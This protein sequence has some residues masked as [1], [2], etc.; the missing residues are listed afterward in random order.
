MQDK[1]RIKESTQ[2]QSSANIL[3]SQLP[4]RVIWQMNVPSEAQLLGITTNAE[5]VLDEKFTSCTNLPELLSSSTPW[6]CITQCLLKDPSVLEIIRQNSDA[7]AA[8]LITA[9][10]SYRDLLNRSK[11]RIQC[12]LAEADEVELRQVLSLLS[13]CPFTESKANRPEVE[14]PDGDS[15]QLNTDAKIGKD[16]R[17]VVS[18]SNRSSESSCSAASSETIRANYTTLECD[19][20]PNDAKRAIHRAHSRTASVKHVN[21]LKDEHADPSEGPSRGSGSHAL[22]QSFSDV[23]SLSSCAQRSGFAILNQ[24]QLSS[25]ASAMDARYSTLASRQQALR[26]LVHLPIIDVQAC[27]A[28]K[29]AAQTEPRE[30]IQETDEDEANMEATNNADHASQNE[31]V[32]YGGLKNRLAEALDDEDETLWSLALRYV[33]KGLSTTPQNIRESFV[34]L[35]VHIRNLFNKNIRNIPCVSDGINLATNPVNRMTRACHLMNQFH[36]DIPHYWVRYSEQFLNEILTRSL[37]VL[38]IGCSMGSQLDYVLQPVN[39]LCLL[40]LIDYKAEWFGIWMHSAYSRDPIINHLQKDPSLLLFCLQVLFNFTNEKNQDGSLAAVESKASSSSSNGKE[41]YSAAE[42]N[43]A[44]F[45]HSVSIICFILSHS[46]GRSLLNHIELA[47]IRPGHPCIMNGSVKQLVHAMLQYLLQEKIHIQPTCYGRNALSSLVKGLMDLACQ[48]G[49]CIACF[50]SDSEI[51]SND[52]P[53]HLLLT[54]LRCFYEKTSSTDAQYHFTQTKKSVLEMQIQLM[55]CLASHR[56][57]L[58]LLRGLQTKI[59]EWSISTVELFHE[60]INRS[61]AKYE[62]PEAGNSFLNDRISVDQ[63]IA[64]MQISM[65][66]H[67]LSITPEL[68]HL[69]KLCTQVLRLWKTMMPKSRD[70]KRGASAMELTHI[71]ERAIRT[72]GLQLAETCR[73]VAYLSCAGLLHECAQ[74]LADHLSNHSLSLDPRSAGIIFTQLCSTQDGIEALLSAGLVDKQFVEVW[75]RLSINGH[76]DCDSASNVSTSSMKWSVDPIDRTLFKPFIALV[77]LTSS[78]CAFGQ[79]FVT[80]DSRKA[81]D[82][83]KTKTSTPTSSIVEFLRALV[84]PTSTQVFLDGDQAQIFGMR[85]LSCMMADLDCMLFIEKQLNLLDGLLH[86]QNEN[87]SGTG[88]VI[89]DALSVERNYLLVKCIVTGG[90]NERILPHRLICEHTLDPYPYPMLTS[91]WSPE[92]LTAFDTLDDRNSLRKACAVHPCTSWY[93]QMFQED[94]RSFAS[95]CWSPLCMSVCQTS[96]SFMEAPNS[97]QTINRWQQICRDALFRSTF[98]AYSDFDD[99]HVITFMLRAVQCGKWLYETENPCLKELT[100][101][102]DQRAMETLLLA[103]EEVLGAQF[104]VRYGQRIGLLEHVGHWSEL[105]NTH[106]HSLCLLLKRCRWSLEN[107]TTS[108]QDTVVNS[109]AS[110]LESCFSHGFDWFAATVFLIS[111]GNLDSTWQFLSRFAR[112]IR[113]VYLWPIRGRLLFGKRSANSSL[114]PFIT[115]SCHFL[116]HIVALECPT[117]YNTFQ[118]VQLCPSQIFM[119]WVNQCFWN[120]LNWCDIVDY[121][122]T[123]LLHPAGYQIYFTVSIL[124]HLH[125][126]IAKCKLERPT[127][128][129][130]QPEQLIVFLQEEPIRGFHLKDHISYIN[131]LHDKYG[132]GLEPLLANLNPFGL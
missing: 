83:S 121:I 73:G 19:I 52:S 64:L 55:Q 117:L 75:R 16:I 85:L 1:Y 125:K 4:S 109:V 51:D 124:R 31:P 93:Q 84:L 66:L 89:L 118:M 42:L 24:A 45:V 99:D 115:N 128:Q 37:E 96:A 44:L 53:A 67:N 41:Y 130:Q 50:K 40:S 77:K 76:A 74:D 86:A 28:W 38:S 22:S 97:V 87:R 123:C 14:A 60:V 98:S 126:T 47:K 17:R 48:P 43:Y 100:T 9:L 18:G 110:S 113:S 80:V 23:D 10:P 88:A 105:T 39:P 90:P 2:R 116:N 62:V 104:A 107:C 63:L 30:D 61:L 8:S 54:E 101:V 92:D 21:T 95:F 127:E 103:E 69:D 111:K 56:E 65:K 122:I 78:F 32:K 5:S 102:E 20:S 108:F 11:E 35:T 131:A 12:F 119:R 33:S 6:K 25:L 13:R 132:Q 15:L 82:D 58:I 57:G 79:H 81:K 68:D 3:Q 106:V 91:S 26:Q 71:Q 72:I 49:T 34:L 129:E 27:E 7:E 36:R 70:H 59:G 46:R 120:Y 114:T 29:E 112:D 94:P